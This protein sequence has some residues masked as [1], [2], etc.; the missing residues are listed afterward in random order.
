MGN[1]LDFVA[2]EELFQVGDFVV[3]NQAVDLVEN[4]FIEGLLQDCVG[5]TLEV[6]V[7][8]LLS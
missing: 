8:S 4:L 6:M 5:F 1:A 3:L 7:N 2:L